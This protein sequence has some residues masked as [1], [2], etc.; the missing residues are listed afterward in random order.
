MQSY[1]LPI[2]VKKKNHCKLWYI[3]WTGLSTISIGPIMIG[4]LYFE[5]DIKIDFLLEP[6]LNLKAHL[7]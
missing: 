7:V 5:K 6:F 2:D 1:Y 4:I 3:S